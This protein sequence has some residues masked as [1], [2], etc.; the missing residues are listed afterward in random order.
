[1]YAITPDEVY[2]DVKK[3]LPDKPAV[4]FDRDGT[5]CRDSGYINDMDDLRIFKETDSL[6]P[7][8]ERGFALIGIT[9]QSGIARG[10]VDEAFVKEVDNIFID[11]YGFDDF[12]YC[13]HHPDDHCSCRKP[14]TGMLLEARAK[15]KIDFKR[16]YVV[17]DK[18]ADILLAKAVGAKAILVLTG[19][20]KESERADFVAKDLADAV[21]F[22]LNDGQK[23]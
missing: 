9:N 11:Q 21:D 1:M 20:A 6:G 23:S 3:V 12:Y 22:I 19:E 18:E 17:G 14:E 7:L 8:K 15:H 4:F 2:Y 13:P 5:L 10:V 16:S